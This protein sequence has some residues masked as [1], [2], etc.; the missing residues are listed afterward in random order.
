[1]DEVIATRGKLRVV[2]RPD[3]DAADPRK[4]WDLWTD[5]DVQAWRDGEVYGWIVQEE[6]TWTTTA[7]K[8]LPAVSRKEWETVDACYGF[9]GRDYAV[10]CAREA[11]ASYPDTSEN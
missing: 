2:L 4:E 9:Y 11:L 3:T 6:V 10:E 7:N 8:Y 1:M 5:A